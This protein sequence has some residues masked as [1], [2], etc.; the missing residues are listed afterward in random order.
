MGIESWQFCLY[1]IS[2]YKCKYL[3]SVSSHVT[4]TIYLNFFTG[5]YNQHILLFFYSSMIFVNCSE[6]EVRFLTQTIY[7]WYVNTSDIKCLF[8]I[9]RLWLIL[10]KFYNNCYLNVWKSESSIFCHVF[11]LNIIAMFVNLLYK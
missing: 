4:F 7:L 2:S 3:K 5:I 1:F 9:K 8:K 11:Y 6:L 10:C